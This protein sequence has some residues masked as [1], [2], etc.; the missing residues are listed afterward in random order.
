[1]S[2]TFSLDGSLLADKMLGSL[3]V[4]LEVLGPVSLIDIENEV[5]ETTIVLNLGSFLFNR[6]S[7]LLVG[8]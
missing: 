7:I 5:S 1:M 4:I 6:E 8:N 3:T 2:I